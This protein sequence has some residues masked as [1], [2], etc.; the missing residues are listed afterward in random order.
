VCLPAGPPKDNLREEA[1]T[2]QPVKDGMTRMYQLT[3]PDHAQ[4]TL[5]YDPDN[6]IAVAKRWIGSMDSPRAKV[7][8][9][10][11]PSFVRLSPHASLGV[12]HDM[13]LTLGLLACCLHS[14]PPL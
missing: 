13:R 5:F 11:T 9:A 10:P 1:W 2:L 6:S 12:M 14:G 8:H 4:S 3:S 7:R